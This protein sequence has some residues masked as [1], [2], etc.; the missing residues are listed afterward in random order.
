MIEEG[1]I[2]KKVFE[3]TKFSQQQQ[4]STLKNAKRIYGKLPNS[5]NGIKSNVGIVVGRVQSGKTANV[6]TLSALALD[7]DHKIIILFL[8]DTNNLLTQNTDR[9][10]EAFKGI[11][12]VE[13]IK[14]AKDGDFD[15][16]LDV[17]T[18]NAAYHDEVKLIICSLKHAKHI[19]EIKN[20]IEKSPYKDDY[21]LIIDDEGDDIGLNTS[22]FK[23]KYALDKKGNL[24]EAERTSTNR[25]IVK[26]KNSFNKA[27]YVS[28]TATPEANILLQD[29]QQLAPSYC[30]TLEPNPGYTGLLTFHGE[31]SNHV[32]EIHDF[33]NLNQENGLPNSFEDAFIFF[34]AGCIIRKIREG[35]N[36]FKHSMMVH[37][38]HKIENHEVVYGK[39]EAYISQLQYNLKKNNQSGKIFIT[40]VEKYFN[41]LMPGEPFDRFMILET[42]ER[43]KIHLV[44]SVSSS[45]DLKKAMKLLPYHLVIGG[46]MLDR[47]IT[48]EG[49]S[50]TYMIRMA[51]QGQVD[52]LLQRARWFGY[53]QSY[54]D[55]CRVYLPAE[56]NQQ[57]KNLIEI[58][59][60]IWQFLYECDKKDL[61]L[62]NLVP[63]LQMPASMKLT[64]RNKADYV[65][66]D[67][68]TSVKAQ[69]FI[70][71]D[72]IKNNENKVLVDNLDWG[73]AIDS[74]FNDYQEHKFLTIPKKEFITFLD[75]YKFS[76]E[77]SINSD[78]IKT[79]LN[80]VKS[81]LVDIWYMRYKNGEQRSTNDYKIKALLQGHSE[82][83][84]P[85]DPNYYMGDRYLK[86]NNLSV[87]IHR[88]IL[89]NGID[90]QYKKGDNVIM[91]AF[92][93][94]NDYIG[95]IAARK[96]SHAEI[97]DKL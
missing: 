40:E 21:A 36:K 89:K 7:N 86:T 83:L 14:K 43:M 55:L 66:H 71:H 94:P 2:L 48:I 87:Q 67:L 23:E 5:K 11:D 33:I 59:E 75:S 84:D 70:V 38:C 46:N 42:V 53:K 44:N 97:I 61:D 78:Y 90:D 31:E 54:I 17:K 79:L 19:K 25:E 93:T 13:V 39:V 77:D 91:L 69:S 80:K 28:L 95:G 3:N 82:G 74:K 64:G 81:D 18:L 16:T 62:K 12:G 30:V 96:M 8:S 73:N 63:V 41:E 76:D 15:T 1:S 34:I 6:I 65:N 68:F 29:F 26:L 57:F 72:P 58:E 52:T 10:S 85:K 56:L 47:G 51:Q 37:P 4:N 60:S 22:A 50:V 92:I 49:L 24:I 27:A 32:V 88:V 45:N 9:F 35:K 20:L